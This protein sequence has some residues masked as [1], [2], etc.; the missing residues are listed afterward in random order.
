MRPTYMPYHF[1]QIEE[2]D[3]EM[4]DLQSNMK[5]KQKPPP[6]LAELD[7]LIGHYKEHVDNLEKVLRCIDNE[8]IVPDELEDLKNDVDSY[9]VRG[10]MKDRAGD[11]A[12][13]CMTFTCGMISTHN[14]R[15]LIYICPLS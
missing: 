12:I 11:R 10:C 8:T 1:V 13:N 3:Y 6:R 9:L 5:K 14:H 2:F 7:E 15:M 4:E